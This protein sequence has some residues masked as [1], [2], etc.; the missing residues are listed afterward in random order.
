MADLG[1]NL[2]V[3]EI[4]RKIF[5]YIPGEKLGLLLKIILLVAELVAQK[6]FCLFIFMF[7]FEKTLLLQRISS[8]FEKMSCNPSICV[9]K[10]RTNED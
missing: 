9:L 3:S 7:V 1:S 2:V 10:F 8:D 6:I 4:C 5:S